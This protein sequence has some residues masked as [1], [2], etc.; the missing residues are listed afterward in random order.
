[1]RAMLLPAMKKPIRFFIL[2]QC[3]FSTIKPTPLLSVNTSTRSAPSQ[4]QASRKNINIFYIKIKKYTVNSTKL[5]NR[6]K[7]FNRIILDSS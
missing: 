7:Q 4:S 6:R 5:Y 3:L 1:M 2:K